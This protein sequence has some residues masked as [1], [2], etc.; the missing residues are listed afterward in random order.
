M[1]GI[2]EKLRIRESP[3]APIFEG[4]AKNRLTTKKMEKEWL[5]RQKNQ[6]GVPIKIKGKESFKKKEALNNFIRERQCLKSYI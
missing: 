4:Q 2:S 1:E 3:R 6:D 5:K